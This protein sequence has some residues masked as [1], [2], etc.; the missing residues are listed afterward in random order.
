MQTDEPQGDPDVGK[1]KAKFVSLARKADTYRGA[2]RNFARTRRQALT[3]A[4]KRAD[5]VRTVNDMMRQLDL[6]QP[7]GRR[8]RSPSPSPR[9]TPGPGR[10]RAG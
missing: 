8:Y 10:S 5:E 9:S 4:E 1:K 3:G 2:R 7:T 6:I